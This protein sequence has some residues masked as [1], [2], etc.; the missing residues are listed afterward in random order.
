MNSAR[1]VEVL[2]DNVGPEVVLEF[3]PVNVK[4]SLVGLEGH[5]VP[6]FAAKHHLGAVHEVEHDIFESCFECLWVDEVEEDLSVSCNLDP[7]VAFDVI[8]EATSVDA[9]IV[10][11]VGLLSEFVY[12]KLEEE[13]LAGTSADKCHSVDQ[14]HLSKIFVVDFL[15]NKVLLAVVLRPIYFKDRHS[16]ALT[17]PIEGEDLVTLSRVEALVREVLVVAVEQHL[18]VARRLSGAR[19]EEE[20]VVRQRV[21]LEQVHEDQVVMHKRASDERVRE[22]IN[23]HRVVAD[24]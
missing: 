5:A 2:R 7:L 17:L 12:L 10:A 13:D 8:Q 11:P 9:L 20:V 6:D 19:N 14:E 16:K 15:V 23:W 24:S 22:I 4:R 21:V 18:G 1:P 3:P